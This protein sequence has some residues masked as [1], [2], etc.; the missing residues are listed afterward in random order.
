[1]KDSP[2]PPNADLCPALNL[3]SHVTVSTADTRLNVTVTFTCDTGYTLVGDA[4][5]TCTWPSGIWSPGA[6]PQC[7]QSECLHSKG[8]H[9]FVVVWTHPRCKMQTLPHIEGRRGRR[10]VEG[11]EEEEEEEEGWRGRRGHCVHVYALFFRM[12]IHLLFPPP[13]S[14]IDGMILFSCNVFGSV[15]AF[16]LVMVVIVVVVIGG[17]RGGPRGPWHPPSPGYGAPPT[18][19]SNFYCSVATCNYV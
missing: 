4:K 11:E 17:P 9:P 12:L 16:G 2:L 14:I 7:T 3:P 13:L 19:V 6:V 15:C 8:G 1:M 10:G 5:A 18:P